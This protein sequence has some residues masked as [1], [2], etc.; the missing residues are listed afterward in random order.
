MYKK[1]QGEGLKWLFGILFLLMPSFFTFIWVS[2]LYGHAVPASA[3]WF[4]YVATR[5]IAYV[6]IIIATALTLGIAI[7]RVT[8]GLFLAL[9]SI[10]T[11]SAALLLWY[12]AHIFRSPW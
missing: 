12:T 7:R 5:L 2:A 8:S 6:G 11:T 1:M 9:M 3:V 10:A 4:L